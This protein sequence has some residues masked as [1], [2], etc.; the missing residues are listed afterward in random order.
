MGYH[1]IVR[2][3]EKGLISHYIKELDEL[4]DLEGLS[5]DTIIYKGEAHWTP[6][7]M[8]EVEPYSKYLDEALRAG[9][10]AEKLFERLCQEEGIIYE[11]ISQDQAHLKQ[12]A[13]QSEGNVKRGDY[14]IRRPIQ[15]EIEVKCFS[16]WKNAKQPFYYFDYCEFKGHQHMAKLTNLDILLAIFERKGDNPLP[17][18]LRMIP[19]RELTENKANGL[20]YN[21]KNKKWQIPASVMTPGF[22]LVTEKQP[23]K[24]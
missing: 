10:K 8:G 3:S 6:M 16:L 4:A 7:Q 20:I 19:I 23:V 18:T 15:V 14:L 22:T 24:G 2:N 9:K 13:Q 5:K 17:E 21:K 1:V 12:Y 11:R